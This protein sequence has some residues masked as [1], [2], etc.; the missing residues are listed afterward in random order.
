MGNFLKK[1]DFIYES[2]DSTAFTLMKL[3][4]SRTTRLSKVPKGVFGCILDYCGP[5]LIRKVTKHYKYDARWPI[6]YTWPE[7][8]SYH[9]PV[10]AARWCHD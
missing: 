2:S 1:S 6:N 4:N 3:R 8:V 10:G 9:N 7:H 5:S